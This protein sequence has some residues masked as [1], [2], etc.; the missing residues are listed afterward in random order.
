MAGTKYGNK[1]YHLGKNNLG[2]SLSRLRADIGK[3][4]SVGVL[5][6]RHSSPSVLHALTRPMLLYHLTP[7]LDVL[8]HSLQPGPPAIPKRVKRDHG[9]AGVIDKYRAG[10]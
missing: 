3:Y 10:S 6:P 2:S 5:F 4:W 9:L 8:E 1:G 7:R